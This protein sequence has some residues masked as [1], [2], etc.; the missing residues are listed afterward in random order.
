MKVCRG[1]GPYV[2]GAP[3]TDYVKPK[4][5]RNGPILDEKCLFVRVLGLSGAAGGDSTVF[6]SSGLV[7][8]PRPPL[9]GGG[10]TD[11]VGLEATLGCLRTHEVDG[12]ESGSAVVKRLGKYSVT[13]GVVPRQ[14]KTRNE[15]CNIG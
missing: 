4:I 8:S 12:D 3:P 2:S 10:V 9:S 7:P 11:Y 6:L 5:S 1:F 15:Y 14:D 13:E